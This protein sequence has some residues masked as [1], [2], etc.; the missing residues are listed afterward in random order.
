MCETPGDR[1]RGPGTRDPNRPITGQKHV[2]STFEDLPVK[3]PLQCLQGAYFFPQD[4]AS[5]V[6]KV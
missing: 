4:A 2:Q 1:A 3:L 5:K 6:R